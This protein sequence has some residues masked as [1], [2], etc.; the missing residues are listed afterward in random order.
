MRSETIFFEQL[1]ERIILLGH[2]SN[3]ST[4]GYIYQEYDNSVMEDKNATAYN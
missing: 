1:T 3:Y 2:Y 4:L